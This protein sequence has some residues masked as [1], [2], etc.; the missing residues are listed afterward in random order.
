[1]RSGGIGASLL[2]VAL[3]AILYWGVSADAEGLDLDMIGLILLI[4]GGLGLVLSLVMA[5]ASRPGRGD[6]DITVIER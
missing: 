3:G 1:M 2:L 5:A 4:V 6:Q